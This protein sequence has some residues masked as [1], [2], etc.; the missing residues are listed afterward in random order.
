MSKYINTVI[1][2]MVKTKDFGPIKVREY[3]RKFKSTITT[4]LCFVDMD[5]PIMNGDVIGDFQWRRD[6]K[7]PL[8]RKQALKYFSEIFQ[9]FGLEVE[10][11]SYSRKAGCSMCPCSPGFVVTLKDAFYT[12][13]RIAI[14]S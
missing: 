10:K 12:G 14:W 9:N 2:S 5:R 1:E 6:H 3:D 11:V 7:A 4:V 13:R 8:T